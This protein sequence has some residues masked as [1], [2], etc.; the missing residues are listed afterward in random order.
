MIAS[1]FLRLLSIHILIQ[2]LLML[3]T[4]S[5]SNVTCNLIAI[6]I[7]VTNIATIFDL[8]KLPYQY[9][10]WL[11]LLLLLYAVMV[12]IGKKIMQHKKRKVK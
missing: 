4:N 2:N 6:L 5:N 8:A 10:A 7:V 1:I 3:C 9:L 11:I 12:Q